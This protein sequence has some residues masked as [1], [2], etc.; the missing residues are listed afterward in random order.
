M[1]HHE[2]NEQK[3]LFEWASYIPLLKWLHSIPNGAH[4]AGDSKARA[5]QMRRLKEQGLKTGVSDVFLPLPVTRV[6]GVYAGLYIEMKRRKVDGPAKVSSDQQDFQQAMT[7]AG[8]KCVICYG[9]D[10]AIVAI[11]KYLGSKL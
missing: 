3:V 2:D 7:A 6:G 11:K 9:A 10:E 1:K 8:Y 4:L 5:M